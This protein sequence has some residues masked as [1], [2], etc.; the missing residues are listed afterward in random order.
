MEF[1]KSTSTNFDEYEVMIRRRTENDYSAYCPQINLQINGLTHEQVEA[2]MQDKIH[3][4]IEELS[5][6]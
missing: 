3:K 4:H 5:A 6:E 2:M 1:K